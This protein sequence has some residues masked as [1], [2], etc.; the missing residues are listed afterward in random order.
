MQDLW[1]SVAWLRK[2]QKWTEEWMSR[3]DNALVRFVPGPIAFL[4][5]LERT[6]SV[7]AFLHPT[8]VPSL[9][10]PFPLILRLHHRNL[11]LFLKYQPALTIV[12][13]ISPPT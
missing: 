3:I 12:R 7:Q 8:C 2:R 4:Q 9:S 1:G 10:P 6:D 13:E 5:G 11:S